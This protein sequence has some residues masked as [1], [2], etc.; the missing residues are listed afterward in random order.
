MAFTYY[1]TDNA[2]VDVTDGSD[3]NETMEATEPASPTTNAGTIGSGVTDLISHTYTTIGSVPGLTEWPS[4]DYD[5]RLNCVA[6]GANVTFNIALVRVDSTGALVSTLGT[7]TDDWSTT[8]LKTFTHNLA[9]P[10]T[11]NAGDRLQ[12]RA[13]ATRPADHGNQD[14]DFEVGTG[15]GNS[16]RIDTPITFVSVRRVFIVD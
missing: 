1:C 3:F 7:S 10:L 8:G 16:S 12:I 5:C 13:L 14:L 15:S 11:V 2:S 6:I 4:G 9:S